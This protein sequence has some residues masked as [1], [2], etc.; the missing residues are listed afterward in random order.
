[1]IDEHIKLNA[2]VGNITLQGKGLECKGFDAV[3]LW[4]GTTTV[5]TLTSD[6]N[7][8]EI[9]SPLTTISNNLNVGGTLSISG[10]VQGYIAS[11]LP[12][13]FTTNRTITINSI[14]F[15][16]YDVNLNH[17][18]FNTRWTQSKTI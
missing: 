1:M 3:Q 16:A 4:A 15:A 10:K 11:R 13:F 17:K 18:N 8:M 2:M 6:G 9:Q 7:T 12:I 5:S 14:N